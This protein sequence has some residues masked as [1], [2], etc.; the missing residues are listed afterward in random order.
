MGPN[1]TSFSLTKTKLKPWESCEVPYSL[2][3]R[4]PM[5]YRFD[6][7]APQAGFDPLKLSR[8]VYR[9]ALRGGISRPAAPLL[10]S[11]TRSR[12]KFE[13]E[14]SPESPTA[15]IKMLGPHVTPLM[16]RVFVL[17]G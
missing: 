11:G 4:N 6:L 14:D 3:I 5:L 17:V 9:T 1:M 13:L 16:L 15:D 7:R 8:L 2:A 10:L 12:V